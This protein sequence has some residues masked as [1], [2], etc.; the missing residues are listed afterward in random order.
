VTLLLAG[1]TS[2]FWGAAPVAGGCDA[3]PGVTSTVLAAGGA[4]EEL[5]LELELLE[6]SADMHGW[7][8]TVS[9][10]VLRGTTS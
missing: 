2:W 1:T 10:S 3:P 8:A 6:A 5:L 7:I 4:A 9:V